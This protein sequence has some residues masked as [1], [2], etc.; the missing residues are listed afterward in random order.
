M[1]EVTGMPAT[2]VVIGGSSELAQAVLHRLAG[3][4]LRAVVLAGRDAD[5]LASAAEKLGAAGVAEVTTAVL[6][7]T[8]SADHAGF[9][10]DTIARLGRIDLVLVAAGV[11]PAE[12]LDALEPI[13][14][15]AALTTNFVGPAALTAAF[16][17]RLVAQGSGRIVVFSSVAGVR[18]RRANFVYGAAK[19]GL[20]GFAQGLG[21]ALVG[22][23]VAL[24]IVRPG[25]VPTKMTAGRP[26][27]PFATTPE[28]VGDAVVAALESGTDVVYIP[29]VLRFL[30]AGA[31]LAPRA[32]W[33][34]MPS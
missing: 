1:S 27:Q 32:L 20:D 15:A 28:A 33:R 12:G 30:F 25:F 7:V 3:H 11:L 29:G 5:A 34:R 16:A 19:A 26:A 14:V 21:D 6:D 4:R 31:R 24:L 10:E 2:A 23:G 22:T 9:V 17:R 18:V 8:A 13:A